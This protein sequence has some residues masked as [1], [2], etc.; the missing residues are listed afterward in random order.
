MEY[1][2]VLRCIAHCP[3]EWVTKEYIRNNTKVKE[4]TLTN[5]LTALTKRNIIIAKKGVKGLY[6]LPTQS[7]ATWI[8]AYTTDIQKLESVPNEEQKV[9][10]VTK[11][12]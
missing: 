8:K 4:S 1:R 3:D 7:F 9:L 6:R 5:A 11:A 2:Q 12:E 10:F